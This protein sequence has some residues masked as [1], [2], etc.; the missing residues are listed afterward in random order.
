M[1][2]LLSLTTLLVALVIPTVS[3]QSTAQDEVVVQIEI[4]KNGSVVARP[5]LRTRIGGGKASLDI[6]GGPRLTVELVRHDGAIEA[7]SEFQFSD[8][9]RPTL[10][11]KLGQE[12]ASARI[13]A[14]KDTFDIKM[15]LRPVK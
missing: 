9:A 5:T 3:A 2:K 12:P 1:T 15:N 13:V 8:G 10:R 6:N 4:A 11:M 7:I 14:G